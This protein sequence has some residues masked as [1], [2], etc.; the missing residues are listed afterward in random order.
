M[1]GHAGGCRAHTN[2]RLSRSHPSPLHHPTPP[3]A[4]HPHNPQA[5]SHDSKKAY[6][7]VLRP[8]PER[9]NLMIVD[10]T[11]LQIKKEIHGIARDLQSAVTSIDGKL[12][13]LISGGFQRFES[14][15]FVLDTETD[16]PLGFVPAPGGHHDI[17][18]VPRTVADMKYTRA[19]CM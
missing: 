5:F 3:H 2:R 9:S 14:T 4:L 19:V 13:F 11:T 1:I 15:L 16:T 6:F 8:K 7:V 12:L 10:L 17:A 18:L